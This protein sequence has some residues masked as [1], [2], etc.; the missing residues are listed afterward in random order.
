MANRESYPASLFPLRGDI[1]AEAG[2]VAVVVQGL[3]TIPIST[4]LPDGS[5]AVG[6]SPALIAL[7]GSN[8]SQAVWTP[9]SLDSSI[10]VESIP[11]SDDYDIGVELPLSTT[12]SPVFVEGA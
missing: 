3:Q 7:G 11:V 6:V 8:V 5:A 2:A 12:G 9:V 1:S 10:L 4:Q